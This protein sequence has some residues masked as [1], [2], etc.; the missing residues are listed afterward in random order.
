MKKIK[1]LIFTAAIVFFSSCSEEW[2]TI[3]PQGEASFE[4]LQS[5]KGVDLLLIGAYAD[6]DGVTGQG[7]HPEGWPSTVSNWVWGS[8]QA[9]DAYKGSNFGDQANINDIA[10]HYMTADNTY[11]RSHWTIL[12]DGVVRCNYL[13]KAINTAVG[14]SDADKTQATAQAKFL[15]AHYYVELTQVHGKVPYLDENTVNPTAV[16]NDHL[17]WPEIEADLQFAIDN[18]PLKQSDKGRPTVW[19]AKTY[20]ARVYMMQQKYAAAMPLLRDV[21]TNGGFTLVPQFNQNFLIAYD[22]NSE[23]I[24]EI[25]FSVNSGFSSYNANY[26]DA[27][28]QPSFKS[29]S[30]FHQP[31][32]N[33][34]SAFRVSCKWSS[35]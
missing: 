32:H 6:I 1:I 24:F 17:V 7:V 12:Y 34:V 27:L 11:V 35:T 15:R 21:Y 16:P 4:T 5:K 23:S 29:I 9:D 2:Y 22:N 30:N 13:L 26:G 25:Q 18:L 8:V 19:A 14:M 3:K 31:S 28:N 20:M 33:L 10:G